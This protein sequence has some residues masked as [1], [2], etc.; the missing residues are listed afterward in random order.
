MN[1]LVLLEELHLENNL[2]GYV[3]PSAE[4]IMDRVKT[5]VSTGNSNMKT[6]MS[7]SSLVTLNLKNNKLIHPPE[8]IISALPNLSV[9]TIEIFMVTIRRKL[10][11][12]IILCNYKWETHY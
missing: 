12:H 9:I 6:I 2:L 11:C 4:T 7:L 10:I 5:M 3:D 8:S 1:G